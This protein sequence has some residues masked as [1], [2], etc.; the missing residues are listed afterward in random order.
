MTRAP[1]RE[2]KL[3]ANAKLNLA[4]DIVGR[5]A[6]GYHLMD[7]VM[8][9]VDLAD[10]LMLRLARSGGVSVSCNA[11]Y[12]PRDERN[13]A[14]RAITALCERAGA[15]VPPLSLAIKK[16]IPTQ[17]GLGGGSADAAAAL[18]GINELLGLGF[19]VGEL[20][21]TGE[22]IGADV[23]FC[24]TGGAARVKGIGELIE[25]IEDN[26]DY[27]TLILMPVRG[28]STREAFAKW[29]DG[30]D[31]ER[32]DVAGVAEALSLGDTTG[33]G[34]LVG[35]A[36]SALEA[37]E[38]TERLKSALLVAGALGASMTG[39]GAAVFGIFPD[40][41]SAQRARERLR[42]LGASTY[43]AR[44]CGEGVRIV[45]APCDAK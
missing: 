31:F 34:V 35:N 12:L 21:E 19:S 38:G 23:P 42:S 44:P 17:A 5:R 10:E 9:S 1:A 32:P 36:F 13:L 43:L 39:S 15:S 6:D 37:D 27:V 29:D 25:P 41:I 8:R 40:Y 45:R 30:A 2:I 26:C 7:M 3:L 11:R 24:I 22:S 14:V 16:R 18:V 4:L 20:C 33:L 28:R